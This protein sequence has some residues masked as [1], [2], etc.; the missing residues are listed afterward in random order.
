MKLSLPLS[1]LVPRIKKDDLVFWLNLNV[2]RNAH[3]QTLNQAKKLYKDQVMIALIDAGWSPRKA[4]AKKL[5]GPLALTFT[6]FLGRKVAAD[7][8]NICSIV[9]KFT[10]DALVELKV[11]EDDNINIIPA[12]YYEFGGI[13]KENPRCELEIVPYD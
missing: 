4:K 3:Y 2:Y 9:D 7:V 10:C 1:V 11:I 8:S 6:L 13:D 12:A 5:E